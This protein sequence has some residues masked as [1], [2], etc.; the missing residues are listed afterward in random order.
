MNSKIVKCAIYPTAEVN[1][2]QLVSQLRGFDPIRDCPSSLQSTLMFNPN[3]DSRSGAFKQAFFGTIDKPVFGDSCS[4]IIK[5]CIYTSAASKN[6]EVWDIHSQLKKLTTEINCLRW[7]SALMGIVYDYI[8]NLTTAFGDPPFEV[9]QMRFVKSALAISETDRHP[10][11][12]EEVIE[13][14]EEGCFT[15]YIGNGSVTPF[16]FLD[17]D[18][19][20]IANFLSFCQHLQFMKTKGLAIVGDFQGMC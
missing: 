5:R 14:A 12:L 15:K 16:N 17:G 7:A 18:N 6:Q 10:Y 9:P 8:A 13:D 2:L 1:F 11:L 20:Y 19:A 4:I 3:G